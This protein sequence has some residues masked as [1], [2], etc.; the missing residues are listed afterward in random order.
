M[1]QNGLTHAFIVT[2]E[3]E[4]G[5]DYY[6]F[7]DTVHLEFVN[8]SVSPVWGF[9]IGYRVEGRGSPRKPTRRVPGSGL[10]T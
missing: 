7:K 2:F 1:E 5:R 4:E 10:I 3:N 6:A 8:W 9:D